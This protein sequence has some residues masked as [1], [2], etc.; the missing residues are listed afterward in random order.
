MSMRYVSWYLA[1]RPHTNARNSLGNEENYLSIFRRISTLLENT[2]R[3]SFNSLI[4][5]T[6]MLYYQRRWISFVETHRC[7]QVLV[8]YLH[9]YGFCLLSR[10]LPHSISTSTLVHRTAPRPVKSVQSGHGDGPKPAGQHDRSFCAPNDS[11][12]AAFEK[13]RC[14]SVRVP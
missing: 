14:C 10:S 12:L 5:S 2:R 7:S 3:K 8:R 1:F 4:S 13:S 11:M 6:T 9:N